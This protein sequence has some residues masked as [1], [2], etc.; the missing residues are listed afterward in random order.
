MQGFTWTQKL[1]TRNGGENAFNIIKQQFIVTTNRHKGSVLGFQ[2]HPF[3][4]ILLLGKKEKKKNR[5]IFIYKKRKH[6]HRKLIQ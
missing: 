3:K 6:S 1:L 4:K 5:S 2:S